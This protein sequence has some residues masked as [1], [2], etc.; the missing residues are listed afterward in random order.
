VWQS[1]ISTTTPIGAES[2]A[3]T[4]DSIT[5]DTLSQTAVVV[6]YSLGANAASG[7]TSADEAPNP[8]PNSLNNDRAFV[9]RVRA[10]PGASAAEFDDLVTWLSP[11]ILYSRLVTAGQLP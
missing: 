3:V 6:I 10:A 9:S 1:I 5:G 7:G 8:N 4:F 11:N 2:P